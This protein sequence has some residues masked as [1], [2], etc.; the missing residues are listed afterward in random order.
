MAAV[1]SAAAAAHTPPNLESDYFDGKFCAQGPLGSV[2]LLLR[3]GR[4]CCKLLPVGRTRRRGGC[5]AAAAGQAGTGI[6]PNPEQRSLTEL[7]A[8]VV[9]R[10]RCRTPSVKSLPDSLTSRTSRTPPS[11]RTKDSCTYHQISISNDQLHQL[12]QSHHRAS[13]SA[14]PDS[15]PLRA[16]SN[17]IMTA[18]YVPCRQGEGPLGALDAI[19]TALGGLQVHEDGVVGGGWRKQRPLRQRQGCPSLLQPGPA[20]DCRRACLLVC[21]ILWAATCGSRCHGLPAC[22]PS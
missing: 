4:G 8:A 2:Q 5:R 16:S 11:S 20:L 18:E 17:G 6:A 7:A 9:H 3:A 14:L 1:S 19:S 15:Q 10:I 22:L 12:A 13:T 21:L